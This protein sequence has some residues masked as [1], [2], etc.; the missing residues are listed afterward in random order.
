M[1]V[2]VEEK[3]KVMLKMG[4]SATLEEMG[5]I[6]AAESEMVVIPVVDEN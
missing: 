3:K 2:V 4:E 1:A 5:E 6:V